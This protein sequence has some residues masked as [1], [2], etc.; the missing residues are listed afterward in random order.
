MFTLAENSIEHKGLKNR[1]DKKYAERLSLTSSI[2]WEHA[3][4]LMTKHAF[5]AQ[6]NLTRARGSL[7]IA[8]P[9]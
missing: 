7:K 6:Y 9:S 2:V 4:T 1:A 8:V 5:K 3:L